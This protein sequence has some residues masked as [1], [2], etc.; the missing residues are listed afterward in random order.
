MLHTEDTQILPTT[1]VE[2]SFTIKLSQ[3]IGSPKLKDRS[4]PSF[5]LN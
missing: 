2:H 4:A 3:T 5:G 1:D